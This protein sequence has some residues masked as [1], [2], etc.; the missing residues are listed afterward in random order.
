MK[1]YSVSYRLKAEDIDEAEF[2]YSDYTDEDVHLFFGNASIFMDKDVAMMF[3]NKL[4]T[5]LES[6]MP[7]LK[8]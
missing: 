8:G 6:E 7:T 1:V 4:L 5:L 2:E 3:V